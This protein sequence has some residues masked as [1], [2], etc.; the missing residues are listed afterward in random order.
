MKQRQYFFFL[1]LTL[2]LKERKIKDVAY[3]LWRM[4]E[5]HFY[6]RSVVYKGHYFTAIVLAGGSGK[7]MK[8]EVAKQF[9]QLHGRPMLY[10]SLKAFADSPVDAIVLVTSEQDVEHCKKEIIEKYNI[11]KISSIVSGGKERYHSSING[12]LASPTNSEYLLIHDS[13]RPCITNENIISCM[14]NVMR[15]KNCT[16]GVRAVDTICQVAENHQIIGI[17]NRNSLWSIQTPQCF[18]YEDIKKAQESLM[19]KESKLSEDE[20]KSIT[21]D[22]AV[23]QRF[24]ERDVFIFEGSYENIKV[25]NS[26]DVSKAEE[27]LMR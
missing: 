5:F 20:K 7:R 24:L 19:D 16:M 8:S 9:I 15:Y 12:V 2:S 10:Y 6:R 1:I 18:I 3:G 13:A 25:T 26:T 23:I 27:Y 14:E 4:V 11:P 22:V 17:P 21:D